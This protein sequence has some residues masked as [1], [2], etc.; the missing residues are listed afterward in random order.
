MAALRTRGGLGARQRRADASLVRGDTC[1]ALSTEPRIVFEGLTECS[2]R[3]AAV[4][5][6]L[7]LSRD[8]CLWRDSSGRRL[9]LKVQ[10]RSHEQPGDSV[11]G[12]LTP[13]LI[14]SG[15]SADG[16]WWEAIT[17]I[18]GAEPVQ[19]V[20]ARVVVD[21]PRAHFTLGPRKVCAPDR[22]ASD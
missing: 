16:F 13:M 15:T 11:R 3:R 9:Y 21:E 20:Q 5:A 18:D 12:V 6:A 7:A 22:H 4:A 19:V 8:G 17:V 10:T 2:E 14:K 1:G